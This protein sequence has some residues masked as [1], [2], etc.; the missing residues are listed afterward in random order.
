MKASVLRYPGGKAKLYPVIKDII[1]QHALSNSI[2]AEPYAGGFGAG[3]KAMHDNLFANYIINDVDYHIYAFWQSLFYDTESF[4]KLINSTPVNL[5]TWRAQKTIYSNFREHNI[6]EVGFSF[7]FLNRSNYSGV[8]NGGPIG[9]VS[10]SGQYKIDCRFSKD[11]LIESIS[12]IA[13]YRNNVQIYNLDACAFIKDV[14]LECKEKLFVYLDPPYVEKGKALY[15]NFYKT[16]DH[17]ELQRIIFKE[18]RG[19][20]WVMTYDDC[21]L[22]REL[23]FELSP[24]KYK[25]KYFAG[26]KKEGSELLIRHIIA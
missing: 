22:I 8:L 18:L 21:E 20:N 13:R 5:E 26:K 7:F 4:I 9:G 10:Q 24:E 15:T 3:L 14:I 12:E 2:Y 19:I 1:E 11:T 23:Y 17:I 6:L 16:H 25:L